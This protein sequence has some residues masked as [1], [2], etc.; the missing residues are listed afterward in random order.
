MLELLAPAKDKKCA[1]AAINF[2]A[3]AVY[4]GANDFGARKNATNSLENIKDVVDYA[5]LF[6]VKVYVTLNTILTDDELVEAK[7]LVK[8]LEEI[9]VDALIVQDLGLLEMEHKI[10]FHASTQCD[11]RSVEKVKF[12]EKAGYER[13]VLARELSLKQIKE[14][15]DNTSI[16]LEVFVHGALCVSYSGQCYLSYSIGGRSANRG[17][18]AQP[19]RKKYSLVDDKGNVIA[20]DKYLLSLKDF[21]ASE[22]LKKYDEIGVLS[23]KIEGRLKDENF[24]KNT[25]AYYRKKIDELNIKKTSVGS[26]KFDFEPDINKTFNRGFSDYFLEKRQKCYSF[27]TPKTKGEFLGKV[28]NLGK[29]YFELDRKAKLNPQD[30]LCFLANDDLKGC[31]VNRVQGNKIYPNKMV[32][33]KKGIEIYRNQD[34]E[35]DKILKN[36]KTER[37]IKANIEFSLNKIKATDETGI[38]A[39][40]PYENEEF[41]QNEEKMISS[42]Q[43]SFKKSGE[44]IFEIENVEVKS[45]KLPFLA[46]SK[47][48]ELRR[49]LLEKLTQ[50]R[51]EAYKPNRFTPK[52]EFSQFNPPKNYRANVL[53]SAAKEVYKKCNCEIEENALES[54]LSPVGKTVMTTKHCLKYAFDMCKADRNLF[55]VD[56]KGKKYQL[57]FNCKNCEM[58]VIF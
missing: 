37:K 10:P 46:V 57:K 30:G 7:K 20:K 11:N 9:N 19:C 1:F 50:K 51:L 4:M 44:T 35:F 12:L 17:E 23:L 48:N 55:L 33:L 18:C 39:E 22:H 29:D 41:A 56:E 34:V 43:K 32:E 54:G 36:S 8:Q 52:V 26:V 15:K 5:H 27:D 38:S 53:N 28:K 25:V 6:N 13:A 24:V 2:G 31:L 16:E 45:S 14:I 47:L 42:I 40:I 21:N 3:D 58:E 49:I